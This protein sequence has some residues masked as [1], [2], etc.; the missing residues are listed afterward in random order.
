VS[1]IARRPARRATRSSVLAIAIVGSPAPPP[2][3][4]PGSPRFVVRVD[5]RPRSPELRERLGAGSPEPTATTDTSGIRVVELGDAASATAW[6]LAAAFARALPHEPDALALV[7][8]PAPGSGLRLGD[9]TR[10]HAIV[11]TR[12]KEDVVVAPAW[13]RAVIDPILEAAGAR[14]ADLAVATA[15]LFAAPAAVL[16]PA[17]ERHAL[18]SRSAD[19]WTLGHVDR[20]AGEGPSRRCLHWAQVVAR[21]GDRF[22]FGYLPAMWLAARDGWLPGPTRRPRAQLVRSGR[23]GDDAQLV[24]LARDADGELH[25]RLVQIPCTGDRWP[26]TTLAIVGSTATITIADAPV[27]ALPLDASLDARPDDL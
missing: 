18:V 7:D 22:V 5:A 21:T 11:V 26:A 1:R 23:A 13:P 3:P 24:L 10:V 27:I 19:V 16:P 2:A 4:P 9:G 6:V 20:C 15:P 14:A 25:R 17:A 8:A 12:T